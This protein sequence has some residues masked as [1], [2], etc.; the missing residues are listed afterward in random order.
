MRA[1]L[2]AIILGVVLLAGILVYRTVHSP[3]QPGVDPHAL[4]EIE[5]AK[6]R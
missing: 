3:S 5:K 4:K 6:S 1:L 2:I